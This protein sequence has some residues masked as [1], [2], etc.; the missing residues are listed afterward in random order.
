MPR[1][2]CPAGRK[3]SR[4]GKLESVWHFPDGTGSRS[5]DNGLCPICYKGPP[6]A[7]AIAPP[8]KPPEQPPAGE[9]KPEPKRP[10]AEAKKPGIFRRIGFGNRE[11]SPELA[12]AAPKNAPPEYF[13]DAKHTIEFANIIYGAGRWLADLLDKFLMTEEIPGMKRFTQKHPELLTLSTFEKESITLDPQ[14]DLWGRFATATTR[15]VGCRTQ[16]QAHSA[17]D[18]LSFI[19]HFGALIAYASDHYWHA[20]KE[21]R[22]YR[23][24]KRKLRKA[25]AT[26]KKKGEVV[27]AD[28]RVGESG[29]IPQARQGTA[30][31]TA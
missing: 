30:A 8:S 25:I 7:D 26:A 6:P 14:S 17:I 13:V 11:T 24:A 27:D 10:P 18:T 1:I 22:P 12:V 28:F 16:A 4:A 23:E 2:P 29:N 31:A 21:G 20:F 9:T 3:K 5:D 15:M 19:G